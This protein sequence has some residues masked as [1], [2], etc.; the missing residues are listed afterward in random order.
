MKF[1]ICQ[2]LFEDWDWE[3]QCRFIHETGYTGVELA[4]F[5]FASHPREISAE[6][7]KS[8]RR[9]AEE[10]GLEVIGLHWLLAKTEGL[11]LTSVDPAVR[12]A[13]AE[14][15]VELG[16]LCG[17][18]GGTVLV[19]GS[20]FQRNLGEGVTFEQGLDFASEIFRAALPR[21]AE[22]GAT[23][24]ME[25]LTT[26]ETNFITSCAEAKQLIERVDHPNFAL[27]QDVKAMLTESVSIPELIHE[28][29]SLTKHFHVNDSNLLGPGMGETDYKP[30]LQALLDVNY[31]GWV[32]VEVFDYKPGCELIARESL[33]YLNATL[34]EITES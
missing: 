34:A 19:F 17:D 2:E 1:A 26:A 27:H 25:P 32:S 3:R 21:I 16:E 20:P 13:T 18:L 5:A 28:Y 22:R 9:T 15:L 33:Q 6:Q 11:H 30:I 31:D 10:S 7:R 14:Y 29:A 4:P 8:M 24:C 23:I 12:K